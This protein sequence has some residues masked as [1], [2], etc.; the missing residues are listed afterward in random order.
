MPSLAVAAAKIVKAAKKPQRQDGAEV[1][2]YVV[3]VTGSDGELWEV[4][5]RYSEFDGLRI[6]L[7]AR[8]PSVQQIPFPSKGPF[9]S[10]ADRVKSLSAWLYA[11]L[12]AGMPAASDAQL[13][14]FLVPTEVPAVRSDLPPTPL[15]TPL[16][17]VQW[18]KH[19]TPQGRAKS[20]STHEAGD[21]AESGGEESAPG[22][23][24]PR[25]PKRGPQDMLN[26]S[27]SRSASAAASTLRKQC[28]LAPG[29]GAD[30][31]AIAEAREKA[32]RAEERAAEHERR[33]DV[34]EQRAARL[35]AAVTAARKA[36]G[37][38]ESSVARGADAG[39]EAVAALRAAARGGAGWRAAFR[40]QALASVLLC[41]LLWARGRVQGAL[42]PIACATLPALAGLLAR[43]LGAGRRLQA[44]GDGPAPA[45][46]EARQQLAAACQKLEAAAEPAEGEPVKVGDQVTVW[47]EVEA[48]DGSWTVCSATGRVTKE[49]PDGRVEISWG[50]DSAPYVT[51]TLYIGPDGEKHARDAVA[52]MSSAVGDTVTVWHENEVDGKWEV[53]SAQGRIVR[54]LPE[55]RV[56]I[57]W[58]DGSELFSVPRRFL[59]PGGEEHARR[60]AARSNA[61]SPSPGAPAP[62]AAVSTAPL[63]EAAQRALDLHSSDGWRLERR[64]R[65]GG[66]EVCLFESKPVEWSPTKALRFRTE[67]RCTLDIFID[68]MVTQAPKGSKECD[69]LLD[70][71]ETLVKGTK[72]EG[73]VLYTNFY[74]PVPYVIG[75]RDFVTR[76]QSALLTKQEAAKYDLLPPAS[77]GYL[78]D[79]GDRNDYDRPLRNISYVVVNEST[80]HDSR[81]PNDTFTRGTVHSQ[82]YAVVPL[83]NDRIRITEV[84]SLNP[85]GSVPAWAVDKG[86]VKIM[87]R[88]I[89]LRFYL[90][91]EYLAEQKKKRT[92]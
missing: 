1:T 48:E 31:I 5:R 33:A 57:D 20:A 69:P 90:E 3:Q 65:R 59:G 49:L 71:Y 47:H 29:A 92:Q 2:V 66:V 28:I 52:G 81:P 78:D 42:A 19:E 24:K 58:G 76:A 41:L 37:G 13:L 6:S 89:A 46:G 15:E 7:I 86:A 30:G 60:E 10:A 22:T 88:F 75:R 72:A 50:D 87:E 23:P 35:L 45:L 12:N 43:R 27:L 51:P 56:E 25:T 17:P 38:A 64:E 62:D 8:H 84:A 55:N 82:S 68:R 40:A 16:T 18:G 73:N 79:I 54:E 4:E 80:T 26:A 77:V 14:A 21:A 67:C 9:A 63:L 83:G 44:P 39:A 32:V 11:L 74:S 91:R 36:V 85:N 53:A 70:V 61:L 34:A